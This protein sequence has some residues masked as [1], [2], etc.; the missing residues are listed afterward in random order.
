MICHLS[1]T[2]LCFFLFEMWLTV[3]TAPPRRSSRRRIFQRDLTSTSCWNM[4]RLPWE[5]GTCAW[6]SCC[7]RGK[8]WMSGSQLIVSP[9]FTYFPLSWCASFLDL[10][11]RQCDCFTQYFCLTC[12][13]PPDYSFILLLSS[14]LPEISVGPHQES[15]DELSGSKI[16]HSL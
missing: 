12:H 16:E 15:V 1:F 9:S 10:D 13:P 2:M 3:G 5:V 11:S 6:Q 4:Q 8:T 7:R 14:S